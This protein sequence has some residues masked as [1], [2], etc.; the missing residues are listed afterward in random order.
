MRCGRCNSIINENDLFCSECGSSV[1][2]L[3]NNNLLINDIPVQNV[4]QTTMQ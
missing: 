4:N 2:E 3:K 1:Q